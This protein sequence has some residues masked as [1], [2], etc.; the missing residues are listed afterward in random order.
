M[1]KEEARGI[2]EM[3]SAIS[4]DEKEVKR[5]CREKGLPDQWINEFIEEDNFF[6]TSAGSQKN[7]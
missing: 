2:Y 1:T 3:A 4:V 6:G 7:R 5:I